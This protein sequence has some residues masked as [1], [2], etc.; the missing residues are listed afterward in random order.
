MSQLYRQII[1][2]PYLAA[3]ELFYLMAG[4]CKLVLSLKCKPFSKLSATLY[5]TT[6]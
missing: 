4:I 1:K 2:Y 6:N 5:K 3:P